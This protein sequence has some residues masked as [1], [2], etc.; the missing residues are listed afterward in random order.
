MWDDTSSFIA[1]DTI[2]LNLYLPVLFASLRDLRFLFANDHL[3]TDHRAHVITLFSRPSNV[4][5]WHSRWLHYSKWEKSVAKFLLIPQLFC[6]F[7][8]K[9]WTKFKFPAS[10]GTWY[11]S[12]HLNFW[13]K[14]NA[15]ASAQPQWLIRA[16]A[17]TPVTIW[18]ITGN[19]RSAIK[20]FAKSNNTGWNAHLWKI[21]FH[22]MNL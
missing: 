17:L 19:V 5:T 15:L 14:Q 12:W 6:C 9:I 1:V 13:V 18:R 21:N 20:H 8:P 3:V 10:I 2:Q 7:K 11:F 22:E 16:L 4:A